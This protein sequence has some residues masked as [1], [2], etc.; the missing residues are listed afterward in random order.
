MQTFINAH[1]RINNW[2]LAIG[3][4]EINLSTFEDYLRILR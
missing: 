3:V 4:N 2:K 1:G